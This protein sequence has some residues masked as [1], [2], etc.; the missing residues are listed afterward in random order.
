MTPA[1]ELKYIAMSLLVTLG[2]GKVTIQDMV[3]YV[4]GNASPQ[5]KIEIDALLNEHPEDAVILEDLLLAFLGDNGMVDVEEVVEYLDQ[6]M[7]Y[8]KEMQYLGPG[9][10]LEDDTSDSLSLGVERIHE[11]SNIRR[12]ASNN[13]TGNDHNERWTSGSRYV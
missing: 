1:T 2:N 7:A 13:K 6:A 4:N 11:Q 8:S 10:F 5:V 9:N 3:A 12:K